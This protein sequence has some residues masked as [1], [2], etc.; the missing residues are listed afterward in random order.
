MFVLIFVCGFV[1]VLWAF[2]CLFV[3]C[4]LSILNCLL[5]VDPVCSCLKHLAGLSEVI[6]FVPGV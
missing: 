1:L 5:I 2:V 3:F 4:S 6:G